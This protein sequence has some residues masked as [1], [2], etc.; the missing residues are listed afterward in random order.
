M[1]SRQSR[2]L[3]DLDRTRPFIG[4]FAPAAETRC[5]IEMV[6]QYGQM[7]TARTSLL[8]ECPSSQGHN[9]RLTDHLG[10]GHITSEY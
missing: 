7:S 2:L 4:P 1:P 8:P 6:H 10:A 5:W 3:S 9:L